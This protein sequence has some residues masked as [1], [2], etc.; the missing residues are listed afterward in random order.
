VINLDKG[1]AVQMVLSDKTFE[2]RVPA[3][4]SF[5]KAVASF[6][7]PRASD[8]PASASGH[9]DFDAWNPVDFRNVTTGGAELRAS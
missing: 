2:I 1:F 6:T 4:E 3:F 9:A 8:T 5:S 7:L